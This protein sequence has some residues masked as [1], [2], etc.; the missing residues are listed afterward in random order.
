MQDLFSCRVFCN[1]R[2]YHFLNLFLN[3]VLAM[4]NDKGSEEINHCELGEFDDV[5][6]D[7]DTLVN[8]EGNFNMASQKPQTGLE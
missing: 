1:L 8:P 5:G 7:D 3:F 4:N 2:P 6:V